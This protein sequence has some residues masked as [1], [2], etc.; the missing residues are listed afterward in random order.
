MIFPLKNKTPEIVPI[1]S[2]GDF[3]FR[4]SFYHHPG[5]DIYCEKGQEIIA[6]E[7]GVITNIECF[8]GLN[9][10]PSSPW[11]NETWSIM[12]EGASGAIGY[13]EIEPAHHMEVGLHIGEG[14]RIATV[15]PVLKRDKGN[16]TTMLHLEHYIPG[17]AEHVT[18]VLDTEQ[19]K[20][21]LN[22]RPLLEKI[23]SLQ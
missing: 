14:E 18:W 12:I 10:N 9:A 19:P 15:I 17:T 20:Q 13:C 6:I 3:G 21:L 2:V 11:W 8:T 4:R 16:G 5:I 23:I 22:P 7:D 1:G